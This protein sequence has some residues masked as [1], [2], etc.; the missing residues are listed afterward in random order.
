MSKY[1]LHRKFGTKPKDNDLFVNCSIYLSR[2]THNIIKQASAETGH[3]FARLI[4]MAVD[5]ELDT[6]NPFNY[7]CDLPEKYTEFEYAAEAAKVSDF[8]AKCPKGAALEVLLLARRDIGLL[9]RSDVLGGVREL[10]EKGVAEIFT[11]INGTG[12][13]R[14]ERVRLRD[15]FKPAKAPKFKRVELED[16]KYARTVKD[17]EVDRSEEDEE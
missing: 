12:L 3:P 11:C 2:R 16:S 8:L 15:D 4:A 14:E 13:G 17:E 6:A 9:K 5:N 7:P 10:L 1:N